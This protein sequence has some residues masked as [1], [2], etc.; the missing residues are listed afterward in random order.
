MCVQ[1]QSRARRAARAAS[2]GAR[3]AAAVA[4]SQLS[5]GENVS[6][7]PGAGQPDAGDAAEAREKTQSEAHLQGPP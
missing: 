6:M 1:P 3:S 7:G 5:R 2:S 4:W